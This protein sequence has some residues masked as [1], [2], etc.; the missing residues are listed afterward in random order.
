MKRVKARSERTPRV[1]ENRKARPQGD[2]PHIH[3]GRMKRGKIGGKIGGLA[4]EDGDF[5][6]QHFSTA[7]EKA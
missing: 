5:R 3:P 7:H 4:I 2:R 6:L 1:L